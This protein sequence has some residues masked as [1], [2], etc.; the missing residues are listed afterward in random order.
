MEKELFEIVGITGD[1]PKIF[2]IN[3]KDS[4]VHNVEKVLAAYFRRYK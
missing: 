1:M 2:I 4:I 3:A